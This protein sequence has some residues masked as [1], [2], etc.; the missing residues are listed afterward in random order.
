MYRPTSITAPAVPAALSAHR[1]ARTFGAGD[2][3]VRAVAG[4]DLDLVPGTFTAVIGPSG[5][6]KS[7]LLHLLAGLDQPTGGTV[8]LGGTDLYALDEDARTALRRDRMGFVLQDF[9]L[10]PVLTVAENID[11]PY[12]LGLDPARRDTD[13]RD[14]LIAT[15]GLADLLDRRPGQ[16]SG[17]QQQR[18]AVVRALAHRPTVVFADEPTGNLDLAT[19]HRL[20]A[21]L[22]DLA[23]QQRVSIV[24]VTHDVTAAAVADRVLVL[25]DGTVAHDEAGA[26][27]TDLAAMV[28]AAAGDR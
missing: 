4:V 15:L 20:L 26:S 7:T 9:S 25:A 23:A 18:V 16:L 13:W 2:R 3:A 27:A 19:G 17:G 10:L 8:R 12:T 14:H 11:L 24:M 1:L 22:R 5:S 28:L 6:G 21:L